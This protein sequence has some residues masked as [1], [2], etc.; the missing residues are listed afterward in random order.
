MRFVLVSIFPDYLAPLTLSLVGKAREGG[1]LDIHVHDLREWSG[2]RHHR[3]DD[4]P[5]GGGPG[6]VMT[7]GPW[8]SALDHVRTLHTSDPLLVVPT[9][10]GARFIHATAAAWALHAGLVFACGRYEGI[11][12]RVAEHYAHAPG[13]AG[14]AEV[15]IGDY[16]LAGGEAATLVMVEAVA[17]L[18]PGVL[19]ND[20]SAARDS[21]AQDSTLVEGPVYTKPPRW[22]DLEVPE[23]LMSGNHGRIQEW[24]EERSRE[25]TA[26]FRSDLRPGEPAS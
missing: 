14:V 1:L 20:E 21:F 18:I 15:S 7:P 3:V 19:G 2:D 5:Y 9:P 11:D 4:T 23:V 12:A 6:M 10:S 24:R 25:R 8:G 16:V 13:W 17:R 22:R 26:S